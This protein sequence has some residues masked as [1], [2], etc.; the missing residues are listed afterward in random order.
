MSHKKEKGS[1][2]LM[3]KSEQKTGDNFKKEKALQKKKEKL[4][5]YEDEHFIDT[6]KPVWN[7]S[8]FQGDDIANFQNGTNYNLYNL[9]GSHEMEVLGTKGYYFAVW[10]PNASF[11]SVIGNFNDWNKESHPLFVRLDKSG[12][13]EGF[14]P[15][16]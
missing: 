13:W 16:M 9:F 3:G 6:T 8:R 11:I 10:A 5:R 1:K 15:N 7:Y 12:I 14:I 4:N 2:D